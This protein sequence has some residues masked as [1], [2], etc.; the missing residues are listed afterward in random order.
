M[1]FLIFSKGE[2]KYGLHTKYVKYG[3]HKPVNSF[4]VPVALAFVNAAQS[5]FGKR[6]VALSNAA[7]GKFVMAN[8]S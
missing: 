6:Y 5:T 1:R 3:W 4:Q 2:S 8:P 7:L